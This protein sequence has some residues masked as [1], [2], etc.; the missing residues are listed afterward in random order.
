MTK[1]WWV[2]KD[3]ELTTIMTQLYWG[4]GEEKSAYV[5]E[6]RGETRAPLTAHI[7]RTP[8]KSEEVANQLHV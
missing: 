3:F 8:G 4:T 7:V 1:M 6:A 2:N 5:E